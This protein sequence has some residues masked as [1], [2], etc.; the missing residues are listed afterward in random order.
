MPTKL[1]AWWIKYLE[2][3]RSGFVVLN[4]LGVI[5]FALWVWHAIYRREL[6]LP[7]IVVL[8]LGVAVLSRAGLQAIVTMTSFPA[9][10]YPY[11]APGIPLLVVASVLSITQTGR[12]AVA[13]LRSRYR[14]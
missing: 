1:F 8:T 5:A 11:A 12:Y 2:G 3:A 6:S 13:F 10:D 7:L 9:V 4:A 14:S